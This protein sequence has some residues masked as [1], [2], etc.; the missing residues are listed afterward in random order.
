MEALLILEQLRA[1]PPHRSKDLRKVSILSVCCVPRCAVLCL[2]QMSAM[3]VDSAVD[4]GVEEK[5]GEGKAMPA[6]A[7]APERTQKGK[8]EGDRNVMLHPVCWT[9]LFT[10]SVLAVYIT[11]LT[12]Y[13]Y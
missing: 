6:A 7:A 13:E 4:A 9:L 3:E 2:V 5:K 1:N 12:I 8:G 10:S 11:V